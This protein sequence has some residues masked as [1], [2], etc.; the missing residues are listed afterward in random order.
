MSPSR[1]SRLPL[2]AALLA[3]MVIP[4]ISILAAL[5]WMKHLP[6]ELVFLVCGI[7]SV[8]VVAASFTLAILHDRGIDEWNRSNARFSS[9][10]G[11]TGGASLVA[12]CLAL[13][14]F[15]DLIVSSVANWVHVPNPDQTLVLVTFT[16]GFMAVVLAQMVCTA[17]LSLAWGFWK[18][19]PARDPS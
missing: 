1:S 15:R 12:L 14:P 4:P 17:G 16:F 10:W 11:W 9:Q 2:R 7:A 18:S 3:A 5:S 19:R 6:E 13:P 8:V